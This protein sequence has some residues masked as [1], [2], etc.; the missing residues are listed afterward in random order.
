M[1]LI[2]SIKIPWLNYIDAVYDMY[3]PARGTIEILSNVQLI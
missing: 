3:I 1:Q 2:I